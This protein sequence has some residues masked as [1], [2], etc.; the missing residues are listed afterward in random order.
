[1]LTWS[2]AKLNHYQHEM[3]PLLKALGAELVRRGEDFEAQHL[4]TSA[5][6]LAQYD[7]CP[8]AALG[9]I[10]DE[11]H[12]RRSELKPQHISMLLQASQ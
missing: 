2:H 6:V 11:A 7:W 12:R 9:R 3:R 10:A 4:A 5:W 8:W 1:M